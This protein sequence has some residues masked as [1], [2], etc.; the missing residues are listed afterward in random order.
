[1]TDRGFG[2]SYLKGR[3]FSPACHARRLCVAVMG[4]ARVSEESS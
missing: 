1:M 3:S 2:E 4:N